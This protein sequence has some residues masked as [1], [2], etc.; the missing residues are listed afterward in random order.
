MAEIEYSLFFF[1]LLLF[2]FIKY[3]LDNYRVIYWD[4]GG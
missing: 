1:Y 4:L 2:S 3:T